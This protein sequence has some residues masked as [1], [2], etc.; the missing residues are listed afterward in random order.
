MSQKRQEPEEGTS[1]DERHPRSAKSFK[2]V[3]RDVM[4]LCKL[5]HLM[6]PVLEPLIRRVV[7]EEVDSALRKYI[8]NTKRNYGKDTHPSEPRNLCLQFSNGISLP[9][10]TGTRIE[11]EGSTRMEVAL[12]DIL[13]GEVV[14]SGHGSSEKVEIVVLEGDFDGDERGNWTAVDFQNNTVRERDGKKPLLTGDLITTLQDGKGLVGNIMFTDNSSWTRSR[15]FRLGAKLLDSISGVRVREARSEPFVVRDHR[16]ELYKKHHPPSLSD[17]VWRLEKIGK[18]GAFHKRLRKESI[19]TVEDFL[20]SFFLDPTRLRNILGAGMSAKMWEVVV[21]HARACVIDQK[22]QFYGTSQDNGVVF[23]MVGQLM[24]I[25][26]N[27]QYLRADKLSEAEKAEAHESVISA[28]ADREKIVSF[29]EG[30]PPNFPTPSSLSV[31]RSSSN[32][33]SETS[34][35]DDEPYLQHNAS[36]PIYMESV[37]SLEGL[38]TFDNC[39][40]QVE[41]NLICNADT[42]N[43]AL[44]ADELQYFETDQA[45]HSPPLELSEDIQGDISAYMPY[46]GVSTGKSERGWNILVFVLRWWFSIRRIVARKT[47]T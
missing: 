28:F 34:F 36:S 3:V 9:V 38:S 30:S 29:D 7:K 43:R 37:Y 6:E 4:S 26:S 45:I 32:L 27:G 15:K 17:E 24:G 1:F 21:E 2:S 19:T 23:D 11:G 5:Q 18:G 40:H 46:S 41:D 31:A 39:L 33:P 8:I 13:T 22:L 16:G 35:N 12:V 47:R 14:F 25:I 44:C 42:L 10:F 20:V